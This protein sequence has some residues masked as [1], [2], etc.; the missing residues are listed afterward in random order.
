MFACRPEG[1]V[2]TDRETIAQATQ[3]MR[4]SAGRF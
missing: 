2:A 1:I 3:V 4:Y